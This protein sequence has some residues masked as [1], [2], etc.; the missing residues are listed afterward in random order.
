MDTDALAI[1]QWQFRVAWSLADQ[2][3]LPRLTD[4]MC[5]WLPAAASWTVRKGTDNGWHADWSEPEPVN[6]APP[7]IGWLTWH[8]LWWWGDALAV[9]DGCPQAERSSVRWP[10][11]AASAVGQLRG[12]SSRWTA[13]VAALSAADL[14]RP[15][16]FPWNEPRPLIFTVFWVNLELMKN[17]A[18][19]GELAN[20]YD[21]RHDADGR[22]PR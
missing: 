17:V 15:I 10:G 12:L 5:W 22:R 8:L 9:V 2:V 21:Y 14:N 3:Q 16:S 11:S 1:A 19:I 20:L 7:T 13:T 4:Q 6:P 18:E